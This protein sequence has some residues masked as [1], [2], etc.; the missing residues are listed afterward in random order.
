[1]ILVLSLIIYFAMMIVA[2]KA[3]THKLDDQIEGDND[4]DGNAKIVIDHE[5]I[6]Y[7]IGSD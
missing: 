1:V 2:I 6:T 7:S 3:P 4:E 5:S